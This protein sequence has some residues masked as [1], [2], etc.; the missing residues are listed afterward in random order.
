MKSLVKT[1]VAGTVPAVLVGSAFANP[2]ATQPATQPVKQPATQAS[3][4]PA[5]NVIR[6]DDTPLVIPDGTSR[7]HPGPSTPSPWRGGFEVTDGI[8]Y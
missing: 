1:I 5:S 4:Q 7:E 2:S 3:T 8:R 6:N